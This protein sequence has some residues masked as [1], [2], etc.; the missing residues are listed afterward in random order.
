V[1]EAEAEHFR[2]SQ[3]APC[4]AQTM[5]FSRRKFLR[6]LASLALVPAAGGGGYLYATRLEPGWVEVTE[7]A[8]TLP[9]LDAAF[10]GFRLVQ[11]SDLHY[12]LAWMTAERLQAVVDLVNVQVAD[13]IALTGDFVSSGLTD[14]KREALVDSLGK[15]NKPTYAV[16]GN[17]D[18]WTAPQ[19][20][21]EIMRRTR[22]ED[23]SN[24]VITLRR[25]AAAL[26]LAGVDDIWENQ[27]RLEVVLKALPATGAAILLAHEPDYADTSA[28]T[29]RFDL[30]LSGHSHGGQVRLPLLGAPIL[31]W[32]GQ[33]YPAGLYHVG[34]MAQYTNRGL[35]MVRPHVRFNCRPEITVFTL[36]PPG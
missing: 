32:L 3:G 20:V 2:D 33:K 28:A 19:R 36:H 35:G 22:M 17:H 30:Q 25:G 1:G 27:Q 26:H 21:R 18:H 14:A 6:L 11:I 31:P 24:R 8:L 34:T 4:E 9:R 23:M 13:A 29:G 7:V 10:D 5:T 16:L 12:D 15:L